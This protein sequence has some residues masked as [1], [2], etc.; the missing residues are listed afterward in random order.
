MTGELPETELVELAVSL[1]STLL[2][3][4]APSCAANIN[5]STKFKLAKKIPNQSVHIIT[6]LDILPSY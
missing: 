6:L 2:C 5:Q 4:A 3:S 1:A